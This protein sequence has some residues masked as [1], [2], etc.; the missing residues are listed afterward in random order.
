SRWPRCRPAAARTPTPWCRTPRTAARSTCTSRRRA[1]CAPGASWPDAPAAAP[2]EAKIVSSPRIFAD[3]A[4]N[5]A[6]LWKGGDHGPGTQSTYETNMC[7]DITAYPEIGLAAGACSGNGILLDIRDPV[8][9]RRIAEVTDPNF[10]YWHSATF[11]NAGDKVLYTD[12]WGG[13]GQARC[14]DTDPPKWGGD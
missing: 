2:S 14:R 1:W 10:S 9:P 8:N 13:G 12:E 4:G 7:H 6:G 5:I 11:S 3:S